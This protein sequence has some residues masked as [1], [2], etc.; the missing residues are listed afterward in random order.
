MGSRPWCALAVGL[1]IACGSDDSHEPDGSPGTIADAAPPD[2]ALPT[3][4][5]D[6]VDAA[7]DAALPD[8]GG[9]DAA[10]DASTGGVAIDSVVTADGFT[11]V[12]QGSSAQ[13]IITGEQLEAIDTV[14]VGELAATVVSASPTEVRADIEVPHATAS[15][16]RAVTVS[17]PDGTATLADAIE[18]TFYI[19]APGAPA[20]G[21]G[22]F[23]SPLQLCAQETTEVW[24]GDTLWLLAGAHECAPSSGLALPTNGVTIVGQ[25]A[26]ETT[27]GASG[28][29]LG[30]QISSFEDRGPTLIRDLS[31]VA[32]PSARAITF[33]GPGELTADNLILEARGGG[34]GGIQID[35]PGAGPVSIGDLVYRGPGIG[36][37]LLGFGDVDISSASFTSC[38]AGIVT[39]N[40]NAFIADSVFDSC[41]EGIRVGPALSSSSPPGTSVVGCDMVDNGIGILLI[42]GTAGVDDTTIRDPEE[43]ER[44]SARG[45][46]IGVG[47]LFMT[48]GAVSGHDEVGIAVEGGSSSEGFAFASLDGVEVIGGPIGVNMAGFPDD[49]NLIMR[50]SIVRDQTVAAVRIR[51][52]GTFSVAD[53]GNGGGDGGN[54]LSVTSGV[55]LLDARLDTFEDTRTIDCRGL[56]LNGRSYAGQVIQGPASQLPDYQIDTDGELQF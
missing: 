55:A 53:L 30:I 13:L 21:R 32:G 47:G 19:I 37:E 26:A 22:T 56:T 3:D 6:P 38:S 18:T 46:H 9:I 17:G 34:G 29:F 43:T 45:I 33:W 36:I 7:V 41:D 15:G 5:A 35:G 14:T 23:Q 48:G 40:G 42:G 1:A 2:A 12:R 28:S 44:T 39:R 24:P 27:I 51:A 49:E 11:Q 16:P 8:A 10:V 25:G 54:Q 50:N 20:G 31:I 52:D 4:A